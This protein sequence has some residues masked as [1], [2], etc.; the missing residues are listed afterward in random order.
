MSNNKN[1]TKIISQKGTLADIK[2]PK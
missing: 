2:I 1:K